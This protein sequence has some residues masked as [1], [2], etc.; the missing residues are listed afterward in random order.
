MQKTPLVIQLVVMKT[1]TLTIIKRYV[2]HVF[3]LIC[4]SVRPL[5]V[6]SKLESQVKQLEHENQARARYASHSSTQ[7]SGAG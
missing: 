2:A 1:I 4:V 7:P 5:R 6:I 3:D